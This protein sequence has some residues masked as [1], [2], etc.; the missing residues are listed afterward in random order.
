MAAKKKRLDGCYL[1]AMAAMAAK[2]RGLTAALGSIDGGRRQQQWR[3][4]AVVEL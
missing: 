3:Q 2:R 1:G 4:T